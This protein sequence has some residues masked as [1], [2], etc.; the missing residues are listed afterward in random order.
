MLAWLVSYQ[1]AGEPCVTEKES[2]NQGHVALFLGADS[3]SFAPQ[4]RLQGVDDEEKEEEDSFVWRAVKLLTDCG[5][6][7][8]SR[9]C[10]AVA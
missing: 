8:H 9:C 2:I 5:K 3:F 7:W 4:G 6:A 10:I 1:L